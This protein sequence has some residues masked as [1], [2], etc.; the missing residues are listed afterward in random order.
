MELD[1]FDR[2]L[3]GALQKDCRRTGEELAQLVGLSAAACLR[4]AQKLREGGVIEREVA[5]LAPAAVGQH[6]TLIVLVTL[7]REHAN[8]IDDFKRGMERAAEVTQCY[9]VT[10][11]ADFVLVLSTADME[12]Y[13]DFTRRYFFERH[14]KR[15]ETIV[16]MDRAKFSTALPIAETSRS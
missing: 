4:R 12:A 8:I 3:L 2:R 14:V 1:E 15:F 13:K 11:A 9:Y 16:V 6:L 5:L 7:E 10:G